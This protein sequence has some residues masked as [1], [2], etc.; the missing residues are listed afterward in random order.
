MRRAVFQSIALLLILF[1]PVPGWVAE[2]SQEPA[3]KTDNSLGA[4]R[5]SRMMSMNVYNAEGKRIGAVVD[6][7]GSIDGKVNFVVLSHGGF[8]GIG[9]KLIPIP[10]SAIKPGDK[11]DTLVIGMTKKELEEAPNFS[12]DKWPDFTRE[13]WAEKT[14]EYYRSL[15]KSE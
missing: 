13:E 4:W 14:A 3:D 12:I 9:D 8:L 5:A 15:M 2:K 11:Q 7:I 1:L 10:W 6:L